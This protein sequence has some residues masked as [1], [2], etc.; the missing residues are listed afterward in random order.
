MIANRIKTAT[1]C[2]RLMFATFAVMALSGQVQAI[3]GPLDLSEH[4]VIN[5]DP[6]SREMVGDKVVNEILD[7]FHAAEKAV[8]KKDLDNLMSL[9]SE[10]YRNG[11]HT[12]ESVRMIW[13]RIFSRFDKMATIH[14]MRFQITSVESNVMIIRCSGLLIGVPAGGKELITIDTWTNSDHVLAKEGGKWRL[15]G[16]SGHERKRLW[17]DKPLHP[18]F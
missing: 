16:T 17:F 10:N 9:Y 5:I 12:K 13:E 4:H 1:Q 7:F 3:A 15:I 11:D 14:N 6:H 2:V 18:L 8:E